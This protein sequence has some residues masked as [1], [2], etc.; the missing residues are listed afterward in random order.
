MENA[1]R[2][3][4]WNFLAADPD[5]SDFFFDESVVLLLEDSETG[6]LG[7]IVNKPMGKTL[8]EFGTEF[9]GELSSV[10]VFEGGPV[11][12]E[13]ISLAVYCDNGGTEGSFSFGIPP[14]KAL[15]M[16]EKN[17][18]ARIAAF[19]G[20]ASWAPGQLQ[21]ELNEGIWLVSTADAREIFS[22]PTEDIW[23]K[24]VLEKMPKFSGLEPPKNPPDLN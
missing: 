5:F 1:F 6:T 21:A 22:T 3:Y 20:C 17:S 23:K 13:R 18:G 10:E 11:S 12:P 24:I 16:L 9:C 7:V 4:S 2:D 19:A 14:E 15:E 8:G